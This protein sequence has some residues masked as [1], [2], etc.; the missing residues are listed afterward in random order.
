MGNYKLGDWKVGGCCQAEEGLY[1]FKKLQEFLEI[2]FCL[3][4]NKRG[5]KRKKIIQGGWWR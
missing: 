4:I 2:C 5:K 3:V 1:I